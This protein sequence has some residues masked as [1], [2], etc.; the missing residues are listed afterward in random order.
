[1]AGRD[2]LR[3]LRTL[4]LVLEYDGTDL[5]G[6]Q[7]QDNAPT[8]QQHLEEA[9]AQMTGAPTP[10]VGAS[11]T[12]AGVHALGQV[13]HFATEADIPADGFRR[14]LN[15]LL[16]PAIA[17]VDAAD[18]PAEFHARF[19]AR[20]KLYRYRV[21]ARADRSPIEE[22]FAWHRPRPLDVAAMRAAAAAL[23]GEHDFSAFRAAGCT[24][25]TATREVTAI[26]IEQAGDVVALHVRGNAFVRNMVRIIAGTL[27][28]VGEGRREVADVAAALASRD[29]ERAGQTAP[30][31]GL[32]LVRVFY[33]RA[34][35]GA[36]ADGGQP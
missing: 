27:V 17:V 5:A 9:L 31:R 24:A 32:C 14:G 22:R 1:V 33:A 3:V 11:R 29:R 4:R 18:A 2:Q 35:L 7:R 13:A 19:S 16:P 12:D 8:V 25:Q 6:W 23:V 26:E 30:A 21:L 36:H 20:G 15:S 28:E 10:V 34:A